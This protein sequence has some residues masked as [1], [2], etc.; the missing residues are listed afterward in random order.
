MNGKKIQLI[1][2]QY[3]RG[4]KSKKIAEEITIAANLIPTII[5][6]RF[7]DRDMD[8][9]TM[10]FEFVYLCGKNTC[11]L[12]FTGF[13]SQ[14]FLKIQPSH[15]NK[16]YN[17]TCRMQEPQEDVHDII[18]TE[19]SL[20]MWQIEQPTVLSHLRAHLYTRLLQHQS[21]SLLMA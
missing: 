12:Q 2:Y 15:Q 18:L 6:D 13:S 4:K 16:P 17:E 8:T 21:C 11:V 9:K 14:L 7:I 10:R 3:K 1:F 5:Y 19:I 20:V